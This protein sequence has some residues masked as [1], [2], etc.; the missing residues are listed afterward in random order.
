MDRGDRFIG[1]LRDVDQ[2]TCPRG[3]ASH[4]FI[5]FYAGDIM[6]I[7]MKDNGRERL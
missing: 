4:Y 7:K 2:G 5:I 1:P 6:V 3:P